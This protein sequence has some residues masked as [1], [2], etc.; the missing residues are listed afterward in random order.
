MP[1]LQP[2]EQECIHHI[3]SERLSQAL[4]TL[5]EGGGVLCL[6]Q[7]D[8]IILIPPLFLNTEG[9][10]WAIHAYVLKLSDDSILLF[11]FIIL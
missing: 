4:C 3:G 5:T 6:P 11:A 1:S 8:T 2:S 7:A 9:K 10:Q